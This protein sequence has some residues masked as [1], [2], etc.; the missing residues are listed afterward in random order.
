MLRYWVQRYSHSKG[1][2]INM[3]QLVLRYFFHYR[4]GKFIR[5]VNKQIIFNC[6]ALLNAYL[7]RDQHW[8]DVILIASFW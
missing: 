7:R 8:S 6:T 5:K 3:M 4:N 2:L 1:E